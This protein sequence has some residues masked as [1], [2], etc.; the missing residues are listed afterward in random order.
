MLNMAYHPLN[1]ALRFLLELST[2]ASLGFWGLQTGNG[3]SA[4]LLMVAVPAL[5]AVMWGT[6]AV[7]GDP[8]RSGKAPVPVPGP[9]RLAL[10]LAFFASAISALFQV[11]APQL[12]WVM[13]V[14]V[15]LHYTLSYDRILWLLKK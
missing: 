3:F 6:F 11:G 9:I 8:S 15:L 5:A 4:W 10:E 12:G 7:P 1:L 2:L 14:L 13:S